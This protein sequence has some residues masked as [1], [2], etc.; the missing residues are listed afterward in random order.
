MTSSNP[1]PAD[2]GPVSSQFLV[3][4]ER[5]DEQR[6]AFRIHA[7]VF[8]AGM[9]VIILVNLLTNLAAGIAGE[10]WAWWSGWALLGWGLGLAIHGLVVRLA[11][12]TATTSTSARVDRKGDG[13]FAGAVEAAMADAIARARP[14]DDH[15][16]DDRPGR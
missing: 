5:H 10:W 9:A 3:D 8:V 1:N 16:I 14:D 11:R 7:A 15:D 4:V 2:G 12:P 13:A 6:E